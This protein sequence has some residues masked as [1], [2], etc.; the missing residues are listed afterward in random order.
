MEDAGFEVESQN[1]QDMMAVKSEHGVDGRISSCH[2]A[3][4]GGYV[5]EGHVPAAQVKRLLAEKPDI[6]GLSVPGM[7]L[8]SPG[9]EMPNPDD[10]QD[11]DV[12]AFDRDGRTAVYH[13]V[14]ANP[15]S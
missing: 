2:T 11:Y 4:V 7:P 13:H 15:G 8:G 12:I 10:H 5:I 3:L 14:V 1:V 6:A 9:M